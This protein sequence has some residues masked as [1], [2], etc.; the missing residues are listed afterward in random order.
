VKV[1]QMMARLLAEIRTNR[2]ETETNQAK[3]NATL[4]EIKEEM[5]TT[6]EEMRAGQEHLK[7]EMRAGQEL[8]KEEM[9]AKVKTN[10]EKMDVKIDVK[11]RSLRSFEVLSSPRRVSTKPGP[12]QFKKK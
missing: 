8:L 3:P 10:Q 5:R 1:E 11:M 2:E 4:K 7:E 6:R 12:R 9:L